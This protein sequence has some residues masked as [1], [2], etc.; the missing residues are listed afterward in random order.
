MTQFLFCNQKCIFDH[1]CGRQHL[2]EFLNS[3]SHG[4]AASEQLI[5]VHEVEAMLLL[6]VGLVVF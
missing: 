5:L 1:P 6:V 4:H 3:G 2:L